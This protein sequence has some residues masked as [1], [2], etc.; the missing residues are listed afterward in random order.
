MMQFGAEQ[1]A[2]GAIFTTDER[3][4]DHSHLIPWG[5]I[6]ARPFIGLSLA[7]EASIHDIVAEFLQAIGG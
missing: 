5:D 1:G 4:R 3:G 6:P 2:F 7:D